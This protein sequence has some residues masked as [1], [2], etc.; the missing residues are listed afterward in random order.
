MWLK[1]MTS[2]EIM[3]AKPILEPRENKNRLI[4]KNKIQKIDRKI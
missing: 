1:Y 3:L 4:S 2:L